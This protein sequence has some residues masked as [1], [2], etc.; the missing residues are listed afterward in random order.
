MGEDLW[1]DFSLEEES[2]E[3]PAG[4]KLAAPAGGEAN[5][6]WGELA[7]EPLPA[8][9]LQEETEFVFE[10][11]SFSEG[12]SFFM[13]AAAK[14]DPLA[15]EWEEFGEDILPLD[16]CD[17]LEE[18]DLVWLRRFLPPRKMKVSPSC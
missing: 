11:D 16:E 2:V 10:E 9:M 17:I 4:A 15:E 8:G 13:E 18:E 5:A 6:E 12:D 1:G 3:E 14:E 7:E